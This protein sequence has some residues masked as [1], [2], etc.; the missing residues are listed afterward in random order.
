MASATL[1]TPISQALPPPSPTPLDPNFTPPTRPPSALSTTSDASF[2]ELYE[3]SGH[4]SPTQAGPSTQGLEHLPRRTVFSTIR[5]HGQQCLL[6]GRS[7]REELVVVRAVMQHAHHEHD[8][9]RGQNRDPISTLKALGFLPHGYTRDDWTNLMTLCR[10]H[11]EAYDQGAWRWLP[12]SAV[13]EQLATATPSA[14][15]EI[16][17]KTPSIRH[18]ALADERDGD[19][20]VPMTEIT[21]DPAV[22]VADEPLDESDR[23][24]EDARTQDNLSLAVHYESG[25]AETLVD[26]GISGDMR[27]PEISFQPVRR[28]GTT[29]RL[30]LLRPRCEIYGP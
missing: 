7:G 19:G 15:A 9:G 29:Y 21:V 10:P 23:T 14:H 16:D 30:R 4:A 17:A 28:R 2:F 26:D 12:G 11:A 6:C 24:G 27:N 18:S 3:G 5:R 1:D 13:R 25:P 20:D 22:E 8:D